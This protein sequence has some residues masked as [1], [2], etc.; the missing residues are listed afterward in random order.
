MPGPLHGYKVIELGGIGPGPFCA[1]LLADMGA[2]VVRIEAPYRARLVPIDPAHDV[3]ARGRRSMALDLKNP[4]A[5]T[6]ALELIAQADALVE[7]FR[8]G[9]I[10]RLGLGPDVCLQRNP[11][12]VYGRM[13]G[14]GQTGPLAHTAGHDLNYL[15]LSGLLHAMGRRDQPPPPPLNLI[16][17]YGGGGMLLAFGV[18]CALL[19][20]QRSERG[21]V[22]DAAMIDGTALLG[23]V[24]YGLRAAGRWHDARA[25]NLL[26]GA[27]PFYDTYECAD[28]NYLAVAALEPQFY[29]QLLQRLDLT[30]DPA[31]QLDS[32]QWPATK[33]ALTAC[34][35]T[36]TRDAWCELFA[37]SDACVTPVLTMQEAPLH[38]HYAA[39]RTFV[40]LHSVLQPAPAPRFSRTPAAIP[41]PA[42]GHDAVGILRSFGFSEQ[43]MAQLKSAGVI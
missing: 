3:L 36:R 33:Q 20:A 1:M 14:W 41:T 40:D 29:A 7:G 9:A 17:D 5:Q 6:L 37:D 27:A 13:T 39:R 31:Q 16:G 11:R 25:S 28:G 43:R 22:I 2:E 35:K 32:A 26:D 23:A 10:E 19:E 42:S 24:F 38:P 8:P 15:A 30:L 34:F 18:V 21:Q 12:L 4:A